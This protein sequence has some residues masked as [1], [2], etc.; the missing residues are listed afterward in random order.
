M[1]TK[2]LDEL[3]EKIT[4][5]P[6][7]T[8][9]WL[10]SGKLVLRNYNIHNGFVDLS[11]ASYTDDTT[12]TS[13]NKRATPLPGDIVIS[14]EAPM[15]EVALIPE[16]L[17][18][19][20][21]QRMV[22]LHPNLYMCSGKYLM[23]ALLSPYVQ[24]QI[25]QRDATGSVVSNLC[26]PDLC[27]LNIPW[28]P[29]PQQELVTSLLYNLDDKVNTNN[30]IVA[31]LDNTIKDLYD[32]W[33]VQFDFPNIDGKPYRTTGG[34][35]VYNKD[36]GREVPENWSVDSLHKHI[37]SARGISYN[38]KTLETAGIPMINL[39]SFAVDSSYKSTGIKNYGGDYSNDKVLHSYDLIMCNTQQTAPDPKK[40]IL[41]KAMLVPDIFDGDVV[42]S[43]HIT[44]IKT[45]TD[46]L[47][48]Y[49]NATFKTTWFHKYII[50]F[51]S[52]TNILG[53]DFNGVENYLLP[54]PPT[55]LLQK[56]ALLSHNVEAKKSSIIRENAELSSLR[57][58]LL[59]LLMNGQVS[60]K[61]ASPLFN[62]NG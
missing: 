58:F 21:G 4:D 28:I 7:S 57:D 23:Y 34:K 46:E 45:D 22:L 60:L 59:P 48:Y 61:G 8:P 29:R 13:R 12:F 18:C 1:E 62:T 27:A 56:F 9:P 33:F 6:H 50:G 10:P 31:E 25:R 39:A 19:C 30:A 11:N 49:L 36:L 51:A 47:K 53:L 26:I 55:P 44:S 54:I 2:R 3:C 42:S 16:G 41:G 24:K 38:T 43:H 52:G 5:C 32:Y 35:M 15:G 20:L 37:S 14:R 17:E 40:D